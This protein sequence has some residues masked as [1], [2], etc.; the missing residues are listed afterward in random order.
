MCK[1]PG[2][3][4][5]VAQVFVYENEELAHKPLLSK[6]QAAARAAAQRRKRDRS[7]AAP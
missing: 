7:N 6:V 1:D 4:R 3:D 2:L 5:L